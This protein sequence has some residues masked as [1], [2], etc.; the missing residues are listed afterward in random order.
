MKNEQNLID[1]EYSPE[2]YCYRTDANSEWTFHY[3]LRKKEKRVRRQSPWGMPHTEM[4]ELK[5]DGQKTGHDK[6]WGARI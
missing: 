4:L 6:M 3:E 2:S 1:G 5:E